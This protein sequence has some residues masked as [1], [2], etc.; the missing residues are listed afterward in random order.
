MGSTYPFGLTG[1]QTWCLAKLLLFLSFSFFSLISLFLRDKYAL[2]TRHAMREGGVIPKVLNCRFFRMR[3]LFVNRASCWLL[4]GHGIGLVGDV[5][6]GGAVRA[7]LI[8]A[9]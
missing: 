5:G 8:L 2:V 1:D 7:S 4:G 3:F 9:S 6:W